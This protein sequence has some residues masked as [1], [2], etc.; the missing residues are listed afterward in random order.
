MRVIYALFLAKPS[1][2]LVLFLCSLYLYIISRKKGRKQIFSNF[3]Y[4][5]ESDK[6]T[7]LFL[8]DRLDI[9]THKT[10]IH[11]KRGT[12]FSTPPTPI[13]HTLKLPLFFYPFPHQKLKI[14]SLTVKNLIWRFISFRSKSAW[15]NR[16]FWNKWRKLRIFHRFYQRCPSKQKW[17]IIWAFHW[18][19]STWNYIITL[20]ELFHSI[21]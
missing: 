16:R 11:T 8:L 10:P 12:Y 4:G 3:D 1:R 19:Q 15:I 17:I 6:E 7:N 5:R 20:A 2:D 9:D 21:S 14:Y 18:S 13:T